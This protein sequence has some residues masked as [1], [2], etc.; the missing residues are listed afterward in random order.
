VSVADL[1]PEEQVADCGRS[2]GT[3]EP[4]GRP[5]AMPHWGEGPMTVLIYVNTAK[6]V[7]DPE[8]IKV[9]A[10]EDAAETWFEERP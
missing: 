8:H 10:N 6:Q 5:Q 7:G 3:P 4:A 9:F 1:T 2:A